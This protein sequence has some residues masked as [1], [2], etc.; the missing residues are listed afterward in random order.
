MGNR[1]LVGL[2]L[3][4]ALLATGCLHARK[5]YPFVDA[6]EGV[7]H[8]R[9][10]LRKSLAKLP[11]ADHWDHVIPYAGI[12][13]VYLEEDTLFIQTEDFW[14]HA[15]NYQDGITRWT[16]DMQMPVTARPGLSSDLVTMISHDVLWV[17]DRGT[18]GVIKKLI[19]GFV[20]SSPPTP[21]GTRVY[22]GGFDQYLYAY[23]WQTELR[24]WRYWSDGEIASKPVYLSP[25]LYFASTD[26][27][28]Y[29]LREATGTTQA[30]YSTVG[31]VTADLTG[32]FRTVY[33]TSRDFGVYAISGALEWK[34]LGEDSFV[35]PAMRIESRGPD[36]EDT[37]YAISRGGILY[38]ID[39][40][41]GKKRWELPEAERVLFR[42]KGHDFVLARN[43]VLAMVDNRT[44][45]VR[46]RYDLSAFDFFVTNPQSNALY[47]GTTDGFFFCLSEK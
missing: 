23:N 38:A 42:G 11:L 13:A 21:V 43:R 20:P 5:P 12:R 10:E 9:V 33:A 41:F 14:V 4:L 18:G 35:Q 45:E 40:I 36:E 26:N 24:D 39:P 32:A 16:L 27:T 47:V 28:I 8:R 17:V 22:M 29:V 15:V 34:F 3:G 31:P 7:A 30:K 2:S 19:L 44:G 25:F 37:V 46:G 1:S 6:D